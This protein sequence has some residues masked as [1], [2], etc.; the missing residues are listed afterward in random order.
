MRVLSGADE[1]LEIQDWAKVFTDCW[2]KWQR[3]LS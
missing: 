2:C 1:P 3:G